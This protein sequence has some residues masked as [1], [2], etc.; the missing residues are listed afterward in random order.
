MET[1]SSLAHNKYNKLLNSNILRIFSIA[2]FLMLFTTF[3]PKEAKAQSFDPL[4]SFSVESCTLDIALEKL[5][6]EYDIN[7]AFSKAELSKI[8]I[9]KYTCSYK[10]AEEVLAD[11]LKGTNYGYR[12]IG[13]QY[14]IRKNKAY[15]PEIPNEQNEQEEPISEITKLKTETIMDKTGDTIRVFDT[16][17]VIRT[18][19]RYDTIVR[20]DSIYQIDTVYDIKYKGYEIHWPKF[21]DNGWFITP[22]LAY[23]FASIDSKVDPALADQN[24]SISLLPSSDFTIA[25]DGGYKTNR[26]SVGMGISYST[27]RYRFQ[28]DETTFTGDYYLN[29]TLDSYYVVHPNIGDTTFYYILDSTYIP[30]ETTFN[31]FR[32]VNRHDYFGISAFASFDMVKNAHFRLFLKAQAT[33]GFLTYAEGSTIKDGQ[34]ADNLLTVNNLKSTKFSFQIGLGGAWKVANRIELIPEIYYRKTVGGLYR[35]PSPIDIQTHCIGLKLGLTYY[36]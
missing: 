3:Q 18:V 1:K 28:L 23:G 11:L 9:E 12:K 10:S 17:Q 33:V 29:D 31:S 13:M 34:Y 15:S 6:A 14:V 30:L 21:K 25:V 20:Y 4:I 24:I 19:M 36:F 7:V 16:M 27:L 8:R 5:L 2:L 32:D 35:E 22:S 26:L